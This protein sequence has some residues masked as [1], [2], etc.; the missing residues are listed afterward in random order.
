MDRRDEK[1]SRRRERTPLG[2]PSAEATT[3]TTHCHLLRC[4]WQRRHSR[5]STLMSRQRRTDDP[6]RLARRPPEIKHVESSR[7]SFYTKS[8]GGAQ[9]K[10]IAYA[11]RHD[12]F[13]RGPC[14]DRRSSHARHRRTPLL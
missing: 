10:E 11:T 1:G 6:T 5:V 4:R 14:S 8:V 2:H 13:A 9:R 12:P 7:V 3:F